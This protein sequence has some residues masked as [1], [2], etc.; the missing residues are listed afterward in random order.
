MKLKT[1]FRKLF[2]KKSD[3]N[4]GYVPPNS[5]GFANENG[6]TVRII[7]NEFVEFY[8]NIRIN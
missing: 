8:N 7:D 2:G 5:I 1:I 3:P 4:E 6:Y